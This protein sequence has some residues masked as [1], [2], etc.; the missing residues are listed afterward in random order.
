MQIQEIKITIKNGA[1]YDMDYKN[2]QG[3]LK[4]IIKDLDVNHK[5]ERIIGQLPNKK[6]K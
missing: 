5:T 2:I 1:V 4:L 6:E 3:R